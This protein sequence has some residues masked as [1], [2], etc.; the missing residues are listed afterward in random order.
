MGRPLKVISIDGTKGSGKTSQIGMLARLFRSNGLPCEVFSAGKT[1]PSGQLAIDKIRHFLKSNPDGIAIL[2]GSIA[3]MMV[4]ELLIGKSKE[5]VM[6]EYKHL[7]HDYER[8]D[9]DYGIAAFLMIMDDL[10]ECE[11]RLNRQKQLLG[12]D[13]GT[14]DLTHE[15]DIINGMRFF[16]NHVASKNMTFRVID[17]ENNNTMMEINKTLLKILSE[18]YTMPSLKKDDA[19]W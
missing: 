5:K 19:D 9:H 17:I 1:I 2:D 3:R 10:A 11:R 8:L 14:Y 18:N 7:T 12:V 4:S 6:D 13:A 16:N 15:A